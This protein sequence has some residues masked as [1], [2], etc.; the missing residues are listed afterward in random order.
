VK[1][2]N[3]KITYFTYF[4]YRQDWKKQQMS[5]PF[6]ESE[7]ATSNRVMFVIEYEDGRTAE[8]SIDRWTLSLGDYAA[9]I[10][11][12]ERQEKGDFPPG[13]IRAVRRNRSRWSRCWLIHSEQSDLTH[14]PWSAQLQ[15]SLVVRSFFVSNWGT[16]KQTT[17][18]MKAAEMRRA[19]LIDMIDPRA[20]GTNREWR[21]SKGW[22][23]VPWW[24]LAFRRG[25]QEKTELHPS[26][27][28]H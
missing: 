10:I 21:P 1:Y 3:Q 20:V 2:K 14:L 28:P 19:K 5:G 18:A 16:S 13:E 11:A 24:A 8:F 15:S 7:V 9:R 6:A 12:R 25:N 26:Y 17:A 4:A 23:T 22:F 27:S